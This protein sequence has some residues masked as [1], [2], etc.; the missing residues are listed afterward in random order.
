MFPHN[1]NNTMSNDSIYLIL[2]EPKGLLAVAQSGLNT[3]IEKGQPNCKSINDDSL[4]VCFSVPLYTLPTSCPANVFFQQTSNYYCSPSIVPH[5]KTTF[6]NYG[7]QDFYVA[8]SSRTASLSCYPSHG[9]P[10]SRT[11]MLKS[12]GFIT[13]PKLCLLS[14]DSTLIPAPTT[15]EGQAKINL[16]V[17]LTDLAINMPKES[18]SLILENKQLI[19]M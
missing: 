18:T 19:I 12:Q 9:P 13:I 15:I 2:P 14:V 17:P 7:E 5:P 3:I 4:I 16:S 11:I 6:Y 10:N 8:P 1:L